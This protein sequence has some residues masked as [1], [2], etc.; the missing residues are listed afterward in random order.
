MFFV[1]AALVG[2]GELDD[3]RYTFPVA[4]RD[5]KASRR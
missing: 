1:V 2:L 4:Y 5:A 3:P